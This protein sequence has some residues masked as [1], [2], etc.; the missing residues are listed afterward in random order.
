LAA[1]LNELVGDPDRAAAMGTAGRE[2]AVGEFGWKAIAEQTVAL[3]EA[4][5]RSS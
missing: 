3:Y 4:C 1:A 2:R 5:G